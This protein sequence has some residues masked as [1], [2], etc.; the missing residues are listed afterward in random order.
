MPSP[1][2]VKV[3]QR[4]RFDRVDKAGRVTLRHRGRLHHIGIGRPYAGWRVA[5]LIDGLDIEVVGVDGSPLRRLVL[6]PTKDWV[7]S[8]WPVLSLHWA[9]RRPEDQGVQCQKRINR[10]MGLA[11]RHVSFGLNQRLNVRPLSRN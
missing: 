9:P 2:F 7:L 10:P 4:L 11:Y 5:M 6:D 3:G 8:K 1:S